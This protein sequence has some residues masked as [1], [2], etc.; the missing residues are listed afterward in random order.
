MTIINITPLSVNKAWQGKRFK[1]KKYKT[2]EDTVLK[3]LPK[4]NIPLAPYYIEIELG[5]SSKL[6]DIDNPIKLI[7]DILQKK[8]LINDRDIYK[9]KINKSIVSKGKEFFKFK[10]ESLLK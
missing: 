3:L 9:L 10:I 7:L 1:T 2:Y 8:Y 5:F 6:S 4:L